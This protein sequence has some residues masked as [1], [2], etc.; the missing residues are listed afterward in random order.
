MIYFDNAAT[1]LRKPEGVAEAVAGALST[2]GNAGRGAFGP[3][4][5]GMRML[6]ETREMLSELF[7]AD[8]PEQIAFMSNATEALNTAIKG[9]L[10]PGDHVITT[11]M[12]HNSVLR[13]LYE[14]EQAGVALTIL[15][16]DENGMIQSE[17]IE[18][19]IRPDTEAVICTHASN[20]TG[21]MLNLYRIGEVCKRH[22]LRFIVDA[23]QSAGLIPVDMQ[24]MNVDA[25]CFTGHKGLMGPQGTGGI[26]IR[27]G[28][29]I[30]P[31]KSGGS[32]IHSFSKEQPDSMPELLEAGTVNCHGI[33]GLHAALSFL[34]KEG[35]EKIVT[36]E[37]LLTKTF[38]EGVRR[39]P[40]V[41]VYGNFLEE[42][43]API[44]SLNIGTE[45][46]GKVSEALWEDFGIV[47]RP[48]AHCAPLMHESLGTADQGV[49]RFS[50]SY[51]NTMHEIKKGI[52]AVRMLAED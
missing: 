11:V 46:A 22:N 44:V 17:D 33:A 3:S 1:T 31:L 14:M 28:I 35:M 4:L 29:Q 52:E 19:A 32:G 16:V 51:F 49:V 26:C 5:N 48:G 34:K 10:Q 40:G 30:R 43:R 7:H 21:N 47:T 24:A 38:Y 42:K 18:E 15:P 2:M 25:L 50:F 9:M 39:I 12:E 23:S 41:K 8:G 6:Y 13:P 27:K 20:V 45:D 37:E 36:K